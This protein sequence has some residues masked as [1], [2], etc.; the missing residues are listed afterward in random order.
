MNSR[1][2]WLSWNGWLLGP[3]VGAC[4]GLFWYFAFVPTAPSLWLLT[5]SHAMAGLLLQRAIAGPLTRWQCEASI[6][7][8]VVGGLVL[9]PLFVVMPWNWGWLAGLEGLLAISLA[10]AIGCLFGL[11][12]GRHGI[13]GSVTIALV[14]IATV[15][16]NGASLSQRD[17]AVQRAAADLVADFPMQPVA[18]IGIDG[19]DWQVLTPMLERGEL[20]RLRALMKQ[21]RHGVLHSIE[22]TL[23]PVVWT[24][25]FSG[26]PAE[27]HGL[28]DWATSDNRNRRVPM[29]WDLF[30]AHG[31][32][33]LVVNVPGTWPPTPFRS[34][35]LIAGFPIPG[36]VSG[37]RGQLTGT[38]ISSTP[39]DSG[40]V[41]TVTARRTGPGRFAFGFPIAAPFVRPRFEGID[42]ALIAAAM[43]SRLVPV[44]N[45]TLAGEFRIEGGRV[46]MH[47]GAL[48]E[49]IEL[50]VDGWSPW[51]RFAVSDGYAWL[52]AHLLQADPDALRVYLTPAFQDPLAP[53]YPFVSN[54]QP[55][56]IEDLD[57]PYVVEGIGWRAHRDE[58]V[59]FTL[60]ELL[61][62][63][64][65]AHAEAALSILRRGETDLFA[66]AI[67]LTD[68]I[69][70]P[71]WRDHEPGRYAPAFAPHAFFDGRDP[72]EDAYR[73]ADRLLGRFLEALPF[74]AL[75]FV[76]SDHGVSAALE[77][78]EGG[79]RTEGIWIAAGPGIDG[80]ASVDALSIL[81]LVPTILHCVG[82]P[83]ARDMPGRVADEL[84]PEM[85]APSRIASYQ[86]EPSLD[87]LEEE[88]EDVTI[89]AT[90][91]EQLRSLG[92]IE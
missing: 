55:E 60:P 18:I 81:D 72:V 24:T 40:S 91:E 53:R 66:Y 62:G 70:H 38:V 16:S 28:R 6:A 79:H 90:R 19:A 67:T 78:G 45:D 52:R 34:G 11:E 13:R 63:I 14:A 61:T 54:V 26:Q 44:S 88:R 3:G 41:M 56:T 23:S 49:A 65:R 35:R 5:L 87:G 57:V 51:I 76:V 59:A 43:Q 89:D 42:H 30:G 31:R 77:A 71:F 29:L 47:S 7:L 12:A 36:I 82:A 22:P 84:C 17:R 20:P 75:V 10:M 83:T 8:G 32:S 46:A 15:W 37:G 25:I 33:S 74:D 21:G 4:S 92:Y 1:P 9:G 64:E 2:G 27:V 58:R 85:G 73:E 68:R 80:S 39:G 86:A 50:P 69:Q 48:D